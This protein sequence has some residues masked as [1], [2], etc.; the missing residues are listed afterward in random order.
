MALSSIRKLTNGGVVAL[1]SITETEPELIQQLNPGPTE[2]AHLES[3]K[4]EQ[5]R[6]HWLA[7]RLLAAQFL[8]NFHQISYSESGK[9][10][11]PGES[12]PF[13]IAHS[14][15]MAA[16]SMAPLPNGI[17]IELITPRIRKVTTKFLNQVE[18]LQVGDNTTDDTLYIYWCAKEA[19]VKWSGDRTID[20]K[21]QIT[22]SL[23]QAT[24]KQGDI[25]ASFESPFQSFD[26]LLH[27]E[28]IDNYM[29]VYTIN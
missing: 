10:Y 5:R 27:Y 20:F 17:D 28:K 6:L 7:G 23:T 19:I 14:A 25:K 3:I 21:K 2:S 8:P 29:L 18:L 16:F 22:I 26:L 4:S 9:P 13:S 1:W 11:T 12:N 24:K 15:S